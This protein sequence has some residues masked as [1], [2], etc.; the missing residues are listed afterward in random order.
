M[1]V[2]YPKKSVF[3]TPHLY[4]AYLKRLTDFSEADRDDMM[5]TCSKGNK[6][7]FFKF[8][9]LPVGTMGLNGPI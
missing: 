3:E 4:E 5:I 6:A 2:Q 7:D 1:V 8:G 9:A